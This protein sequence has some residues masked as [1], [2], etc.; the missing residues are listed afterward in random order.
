MPSRARR[1]AQFAIIVLAAGA[2]YP[3]MYLRQNFEISV[4]DAL[5]ITASDL[6]ELYA[7]LGFVFAVA[8]IPS[9]RLADRYPPR[10]LMAFALA[11]GVYPKP[12]LDVFAPSVDGLIA[13]F[14]AA[15]AAAGAR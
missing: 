11:L 2:L 6:G 4:L 3:L 7:L 5:R 10:H 9:G 8:Y 1:Y 15:L 13:N 12:A 14:D